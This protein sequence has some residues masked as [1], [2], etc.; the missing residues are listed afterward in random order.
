MSDLNS[1]TGDIDDDITAINTAITNINTTLNNK[2]NSTD[3]NNALAGKENKPTIVTQNNPSAITLADNYEY[4]LTGVSNLTFT[5]PSGNF[6]C[7]ISIITGSSFTG[8]TF[9]TSEYIGKV[10][11][12]GASEKWEVSIKNGVIIA[13]K[14]E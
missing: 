5:Y 6:E 9:P 14:V 1:A 12:F 7:W 11:E 13:G 10:P 4:Y 3:V 8:I 2:A